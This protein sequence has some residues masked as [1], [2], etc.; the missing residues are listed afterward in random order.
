[1]AV[2]VEEGHDTGAN[3]QASPFDLGQRH[4][5]GI[6][7]RRPIKNG[8]VAAGRSRRS[9]RG[10]TARADRSPQEPSLA[11][12]SDGADAW[13]GSLHRESQSR[14]DW[15]AIGD[16]QGGEGGVG[17]VEVGAARD[18]ARMMARCGME[19]ELAVGPRR[20]EKP[21][22]CGS[23]QGKSRVLPFYYSHIQLHDSI[24]LIIMYCFIVVVF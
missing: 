14:V 18:E 5:A 2:G 7:G 6:V 9:R 19:S 22:G 13:D 15:L 21:G 20:Y 12:G 16:W 17:E 3:G 1:M 24:L 8:E 4:M 11:S 23:R 10:R